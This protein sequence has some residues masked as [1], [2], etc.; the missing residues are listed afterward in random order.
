MNVWLQAILLKICQI[1][2]GPHKEKYKDF[3]ELLTKQKGAY[4]KSKFSTIK[5]QK[6]YKN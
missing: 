6:S 3:D 1:H 4:I 5:N 2:G